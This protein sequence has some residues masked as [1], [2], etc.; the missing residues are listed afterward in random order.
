MRVEV[1]RYGDDGRTL[2]AGDLDG[3]H[4]AL[5]ELA[6]VDAR[7]EAPGHQIWGGAHPPW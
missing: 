7:V 6:E 1:P 2:R 5:D 3:H 4:V